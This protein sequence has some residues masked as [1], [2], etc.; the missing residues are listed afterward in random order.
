MTHPPKL[1]FMQEKVQKGD[2]L[3]KTSRELKNHFCFRFLWIPWTPERVNWKRLVFYP[4]L[5]NL[6]T[7]TAIILQCNTTKTTY[8]A[9][10]FLHMS[11]GI[12]RGIRGMM[13]CYANLTSYIYSTQA[14]WSQ[15]TQRVSNN[16]FFEGQLKKWLSRFFFFI[17]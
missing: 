12:E 5:G 16:I 14:L 17:S 4:Y 9:L 7:H 2:F 11:T 15:Y 13:Y 6:T 8:F 1:G 3:K 10:V